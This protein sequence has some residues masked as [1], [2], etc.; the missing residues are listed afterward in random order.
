MKKNTVLFCT[1]ESG[2]GK[3]FFITDILPA[4]S[5]YNLKS[6]T[7]RPMRNDG[8]DCHKYYF[9]DE[10][11]FDSEKFVTKLWVNEQF[12]TPG[13]PKW[14]YGVPEF[15]VFNNIGANFA[16]DV[17]QPRY[18]RQMID[19]FKNNNLDKK[20]EFKIMWF[21]PSI[22][23]KNVIQGRQNMPDDSKVREANTCGLQ[24]IKNAGLEPDFYIQRLEIPGENFSNYSIISK[25][26]AKIADLS[27]SSLMLK[28][29]SSKRSK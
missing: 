11:Y 26:G 1:G 16:Y 5:F 25:T 12:W 10:S 17:I 28:Y 3:S 18:V 4:G 6:A 7:T 23:A 19:W 22:N 14:M 20:Y 21:R 27:L 29:I 13:Q 24:D 9:R 15:E 8:K 2:S